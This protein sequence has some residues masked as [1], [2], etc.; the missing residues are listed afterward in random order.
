MQF[1]LGGDTL[2]GAVMGVW[3]RWFWRGGWGAAGTYKSVCHVCDGF[4][5][6]RFLSIVLAQAFSIQLS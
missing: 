4:G 5:E 1:A 6:V 2:S 3:R